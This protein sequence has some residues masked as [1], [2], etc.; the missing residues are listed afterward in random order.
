M[1]SPT[2]Q[3]SFV[4][5]PFKDVFTAGA[6]LISLPAFELIILSTVNIT[7]VA[8]YKNQSYFYLIL[9]SNISEGGK[10]YETDGRQDCGNILPHRRYSERTES[11]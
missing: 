11:L 8:T 9:E 5:K 10:K 7:Q 2:I 3:I 4:S 1:K 6:L